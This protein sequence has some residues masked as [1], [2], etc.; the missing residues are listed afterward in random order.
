MTET[1]FSWPGVG[2]VVVQAIE[3]KDFAVVQAG[4]T[5]ISVI[6]IGFNLLVD[7]LYGLVDPRIRIAS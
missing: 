7:L 3:T 1:I 6:F 2:R 5:V 4:V